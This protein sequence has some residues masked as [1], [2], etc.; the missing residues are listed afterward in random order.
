L[1]DRYMERARLEIMKEPPLFQV[2]RR[3][4]RSRIGE[5]FSFGN[6]DLSL[7]CFQFLFFIDKPGRLFPVI[8]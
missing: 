1:A 3:I 4:R 6:Q 7:T 8:H 2:R 5:E